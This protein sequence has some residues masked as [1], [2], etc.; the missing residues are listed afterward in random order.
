VLLGALPTALGCN[1]AKHSSSDSNFW[2]AVGAAWARR[3]HSCSCGFNSCSELLRCSFSSG[4]GTD[5]CC[6]AAWTIPSGW[7]A[8]GINLL[9]PRCRDRL[10]HCDAS[11]W[12]LLLLEVEVCLLLLMLLF[13]LEE[14]LLLLLLAVCLLLVVLLLCLL[15]EC[16]LLLLLLLVVAEVCPLLLLLLEVCLQG[17]LPHSPDLCQHWHGPWGWVAHIRVQQTRQHVWHRWLQVCCGPMCA[18]ASH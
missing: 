3:P 13:L 9:H 17:P 10:H 16:L 12:S 11:I 2:P 15:T 8:T 1:A 5:G 4:Q 18:P 6:T 14:C 7:C